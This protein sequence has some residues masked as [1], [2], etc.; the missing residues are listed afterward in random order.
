MPPGDIV[1]LD[2]ATVAGFLDGE[3]PAAERERVAGHLE[4]CDECRAELREVNA[5][6]QSIPA[7]RDRRGRSRG[8]GRLTLV[9]GALAASIAGVVVVRQVTNQPLPQI[10]TR[11]RAV[12]ESEGRIE[13]VSPLSRNVRRSELVFSWHSSSVDSYRFTLLD[14]SGRMLFTSPTADTTIVWP[15]DVAQTLGG[16]YFWRVEGIAGGVI[17]STSARPLQIVP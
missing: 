5:L 16:V 13:V 2:E 1:H 15:R 3:L 17:S 8:I 10:A 14:A 11:M 4:K 7:I 6:A 9:G 12:P